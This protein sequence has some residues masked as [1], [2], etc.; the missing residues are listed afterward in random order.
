MLSRE[1]I[2]VNLNFSKILEKM[3]AYVKL[4]EKIDGDVVEPGRSTILVLC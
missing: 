1:G 2:L 3:Y 4:D